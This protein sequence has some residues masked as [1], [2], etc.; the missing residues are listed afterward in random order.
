MPEG[1]ATAR[2]RVVII[3]G[4]FAGLYAA[5]ELRN[6]DA[7]VTVVDRR[8]HHLFQPLLYQVAT[9]ALDPS[10]IAVPIRRILR[11][12]KNAEVVLA[13]V[14]AIDLAQKRVVLV[15]GALSY[16]HLIVATGAT[17]SYFGHDS[18]A[19]YS[20]GLKTV[21]D[22]LHIRRR[23]LLAFEAAEREREF[24][25]RD[26]W[27]TFVIVG[28]GP[29]GVELAGAL[30]EIS[31]HLLA[32]DF[33]HLGRKGARV[34]LVEAGPRVLASFP[35]TLSARSQR[36]LEQ[37][38]VEVR[39]N[40]R[41]TAV[42]GVGVTVAGEQIPAR[43]VIWAAGVA[44][45]P[46]ARSLGAPLDRAG[47][48]LVN[49]DLSVPGAPDVFVAGDLAAVNA[50][51]GQPVPGVAPAAMQEG[52]AAAKNVKRLLEGKPTEPFVYF[53]KGSLATIGRAR[54]VADIGG[55]KLGGFL[56]WFTWLVIHITYLIGFRNRLFVLASWSW[57]YLTY[58]RGSRLI[59]GE[60]G[61]LL[62]A[63][64]LPEA[65]TQQTLQ[66]PI[67]EHQAPHGP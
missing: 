3:G 52:R 25:R 31:R 49:P 29:T 18:W 66:E 48:V 5:R 67:R 65:A 51:S 50:P 14:T 61:P 64:E 41:V 26:A 23:M 46:L 21:E 22:A 47:R 9:A 30:A 20:P 10:Q 34:L 35:E 8:N 43:T 4:G 54:A 2:K 13:D 7:T 6:T 17:H 39:T 37:L 28:A 19:P 59:T 1:A 11:H 24:S 15:D 63:P 60:V 12:Q 55:F 45:S 44:A 40:A 32:K 62:P 36:D 56:A 33:R 38:G 57:T 58:D 53:D 42:D 27:L 16:D